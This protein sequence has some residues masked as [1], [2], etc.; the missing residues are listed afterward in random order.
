MRFKPPPSFDS[1]I[2]WRVEFRTMDIQMTDFENS[3]FI[4]V[5]GMIYNV[6][7]NF[8][9]N[10]IMPISKIDENMERAHKRDAVIYEKF[11]FRTQII[12]S[13]DKSYKNPNLK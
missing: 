9:V 13:F 8:D 3:A 1:K 10:F 6:I 4:V 2:G 12:P 7:S 5:L 11:W